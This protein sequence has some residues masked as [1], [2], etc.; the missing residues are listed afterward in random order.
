M[1]WGIVDTSPDRCCSRSAATSPSGAP[2]RCA[3]GRWRRW[4]SGRWR[5]PTGGS[6][7]EAV[8]LMRTTLPI[9]GAQVRLAGGATLAVRRAGDRGD[10]RLPIGTGDELLVAGER[11][12]ADEEMSFVRAVANTLAHRA[13][14]AARRGAD[15][16]RG[17]S[18]SAD[19]TREPDA[20]ARP[21][22]HAL[23]RSER[24]GGRLACCSS[25][26]TTSS[27]STTRSAMPPATRCWSSSA[28]APD[29]VRPGD[30]VARLGGDEFVV[31][32]EQVDERV[33][34]GARRASAGRDPAAAHGRRRRAPAVGKHRDR[35][36]AQPTQTR[37]S[38]TPTRPSTARRPTA[39]G[40]SSSSVQ[41]RDPTPH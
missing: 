1:S 11:E 13:R 22:R 16:L 6:G 7:A 3:C 19:R 8:E 37:S 41:R 12:L 18:R 25:T 29:R 34:P 38:A 40:A 21:A 33:G 23:A 28:A 5:A 24:E 2:P 31:V 32:C 9:A 35:A 36:R 26:S 10:V 39:A 27:R 30:T 20:A 17:G 4:A 14:A 15:A